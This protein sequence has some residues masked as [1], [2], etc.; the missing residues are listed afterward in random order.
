MSD[1]FAF[2]TL[3][4]SNQYL[5][6]ALTVAAALREVHPSPPQD[7]EVPFKTVCLVTPETVD[8][9]T[10]K[11]LRKT[12][13]LVVGVEPIEGHNVSE[14]QLLGELRLRISLV[15]LLPKGLF[16]TYSEK[17]YVLVQK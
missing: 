15:S 12:F 5:P 16:S 14:L 11:F 17:S 7:P 13:D 9:E 4:T 1:G 3:V 2:A 10:I 6:G 8:V